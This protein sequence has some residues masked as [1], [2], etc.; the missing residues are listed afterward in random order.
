MDKLVYPCL[1]E[2]TR[3]YERQNMDKQSLSMPPGG[4]GLYPL[5]MREKWSGMNWYDGERNTAPAVDE[6][7][8]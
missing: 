1:L 7:N 4:E 2:Y 6:M 5:L 8:L 3:W